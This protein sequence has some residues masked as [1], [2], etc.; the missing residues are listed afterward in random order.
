[1]QNSSIG[2]RFLGEHTPGSALLNE[3]ATLFE[4]P[5][6]LSLD[7]PAS[8]IPVYSQHVAKCVGVLLH[9]RFL[10]HNVYVQSLTSESALRVQGKGLIVHDDFSSWRAVR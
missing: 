6:T 2:L 1:M 8:L 10:W 7:Q 3:A 4:V 5:D 9:A